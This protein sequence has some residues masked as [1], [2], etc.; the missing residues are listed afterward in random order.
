MSK[1]AKEI[2]AEITAKVRGRKVRTRGVWWTVRTL[3][4][5]NNGKYPG[6]LRTPDGAVL[7]AEDIAAECCT[8]A[9]AVLASF[10]QLTAIGL[11][12]RL[13]SGVWHSRP[14]ARLNEVRRGAVRRTQRWQQKRVSIDTPGGVNC[15]KVDTLLTPRPPPPSLSPPNTP[16]IPSPA[17]EEKSDAAHPTGDALPNGKTPKR[18][19]ASPKPPAFPEGVW[20]RAREGWAKAYRH[21]HGTDFVWDKRQLGG[22]SKVLNALGADLVRFKAVAVAWLREEERGPVKGHPLWQL[23]TDL[24]YVLTKIAK[25]TVGEPAGTNGFNETPKQYAERLAGKAG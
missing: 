9:A 18:P 16:S 4:E 19:K 8:S 10:Q 24:N 23:A 15:A 12:R 21:V 11:L 7:S 22:L 5:A 14:L 3:I 2:E 6:D 17:P 1:P 20:D 13:E 25:G